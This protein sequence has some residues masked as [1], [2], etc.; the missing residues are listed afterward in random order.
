MLL[1]YTVAHTSYASM[2]GW[3][4]HTQGSGLH[5]ILFCGLWSKKEEQLDSD[6]LELRAVQLMINLKQTF[7]GQVIWIESTYMTTVEFRIVRSSP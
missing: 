4:G 2:E 7:Y 3:G 1:L 5:S 6:I